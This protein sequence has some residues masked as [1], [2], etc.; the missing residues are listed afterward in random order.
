MNNDFVFERL[1]AINLQHVLLGKT[2]VPTAVPGS[3]IVGVFL[4]RAGE[5]RAGQLLNVEIAVAIR[6]GLELDLSSASAATKIATQDKMSFF[7]I[8][9]IN[10]FVAWLQAIN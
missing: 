7:A 1:G 6:V 8:I 4:E 9:L 10:P 5:L 3:Q 2:I